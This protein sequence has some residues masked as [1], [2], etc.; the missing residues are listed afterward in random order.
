MEIFLAVDLNFWHNFCIGNFDQR[1]IDF[2][3]K[4]EF[5]SELWIG[6]EF[7]WNSNGIW[8]FESIR[9]FIMMLEHKWRVYS[10]G[11]LHL[12]LLTQTLSLSITS[13]TIFFIHYIENV[14]NYNPLYELCWFLILIHP[15][16]RYSCNTNEGKQLQ[17]LASIYLQYPFIIC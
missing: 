3:W 2:K 13:N 5:R 7:E 1:S 4:L 11:T 15:L 16:L 8:E 17:N 12:D 14:A 9:S 6:L 10:S